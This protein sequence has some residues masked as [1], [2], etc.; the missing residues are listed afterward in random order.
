MSVHQLKDGRWIVQMEKRTIPEDPERTREY[1][2]RGAAAERAARERND[3]LTYR[4]LRRRQERKNAYG[5][6]VAALAQ[7]YFN[8]LQLTAAPSTIESLRY[9]LKMNL[10]PA[11]GLLYANAVKPAD[12]DQFVRNRRQYVS[13]TTINNELTYLIRIFNWAFDQ[14]L[15]KINPIARYKKPP[16]DDRITSPATLQETQAILDHAADHL[17]RAILVA[18]YTGLRPGR[19]ELLGLTWDDVDFNEQTILIRSAHKGGRPWRRVPLHPA[20][21]KLLKRWQKKDGDVPYIIHFNQKPI[22]SIK[23]AFKHAKD[24]AKITRRLRPYDLRHSAISAMLKDGADLKSVSEIAGHSRPS[25]TTN[26]YQ[27]VDETMHRAA[28]EKIPALKTKKGW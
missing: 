10:L 17:R 28:I 21:L 9:K 3:E 19:A 12:V 4:R 18:Y 5:P 13:N 20:F 16:R 6:T 1:F 14:G 11:F 25:T 15:I 24:K 27:H 26:V 23:T 8:A 22:K 2:G 7:E